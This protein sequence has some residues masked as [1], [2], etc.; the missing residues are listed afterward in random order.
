MKLWGTSK[1]LKDHPH[2]FQ[3]RGANLLSHLKHRNVMLYHV[4]IKH[5]AFPSLCMHGY[6]FCY[7]ICK[8]TVHKSNQFPRYEDRLR[9]DFNQKRPF[10]FVQLNTGKPTF[11]FWKR[12]LRQTGFSYSLFNNSFP[13]LPFLSL[14]H[15]SWYFT[16]DRACFWSF[17]FSI[18]S[19]SSLDSTCSSLLYKQGC[20][21]RK[22]GSCFCRWLWWHEEVQT[23]GRRWLW[24]L[25]DIGHFS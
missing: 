9:L 16:L 15:N 22:S 25:R 19:Y 21:M 11:A 13:V 3:T 6:Y 14:L 23:T 5:D 2:P 10:V 24:E 20:V 17:P 7:L 12:E 4:L 1:P 18:D 8:V